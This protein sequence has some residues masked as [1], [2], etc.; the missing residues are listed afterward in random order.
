MSKFGYGRLGTISVF[1][2]LSKVNKELIISA[3]SDEMQIALLEDKQLVEL[4]KDK[5]GNPFSVGDVFVGKVRKIM[6]GLN[7]AFIDLNDEKN[8][9]MHYVDLGASYN[10]FNKYLR[11]A[12]NGD[13]AMTTLK[14]FTPEPILEKN[15]NLSE[16]LKV[17]Q[18]ILG[19]VTKEPISTKGPKLTG[20]ISFAGRYLVLVPFGNK[21]SISQ[22]IRGSEENK[23][24][25]R[26]MQSIKPE[27]FGIIVRTMAEGRTVSEL[28]AD[29]RNLLEQWRQMTSVLKR[30]S[31][32][33]KIWSELG[34]ASALLRDILTDDFNTIYVDNE[35]VYND[36]SQYVQ[37]IAPDKSDIVKLYKMETPIFEQFGILRDIRRAFG[38]IVTIHSGVYLYVEHTEAMHV[39]DVNSG[40][41]IKSGEGQEDTALQVNMES[42]K[43]IA[44]QLR[45]RD[46]GGIIIVDFVDMA[47]AE[48]RKKLFDFMTEEMKRDK[49]RHT[50]LPL[51]KFGLMQITRQRVRPAIEV[52]V[53]EKCP[54]CDGTG[55]IRSSLV[56]VDEIEADLR[57]LVTIQG[58]KNLTIIAHPY[59]Q[60]YVT[61]GF[62]SMRLRWMMALKSR[63]TVKA[64]ERL[65]LL[66]YKFLNSS[67]EEIRL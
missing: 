7:A 9:F 59:V 41:H 46:M 35:D 5:G 17:G 30:I 20:D 61:K 52:D 6:P 23:R 67:G 19:Q 54:F 28:D 47:K 58:E 43:E 33:Q 66:E 44:R 60:A 18:Y 11:L 2:I 53:Q 32:P 50:I 10:S 55:H 65:S 29:L 34:K 38:R 13:A 31:G 26:L 36:V 1:N 21:I 57:H 22:K 37:S 62:P 3:N 25:R 40:N 64:S 51:S 45:L 14:G 49:A 24:L 8:G 16:V 4:H 12:M 15:G 56:V 27:G 42:G 63:V 39:I 48:N